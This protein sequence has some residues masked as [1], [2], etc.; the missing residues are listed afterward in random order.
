MI[1]GSVPQ[2]MRYTYS[3]PAG[4]RPG[5]MPRIPPAVMQAQFNPFPS[6]LPQTRAV[7]PFRP[8]LPP[9]MQPGV[10]GVSPTFPAPE[11]APAPVAG[12][13]ASGFGRGV[14]PYRTLRLGMMPGVSIS[15]QSIRS[16]VMNVGATMQRLTSGLP[17]G[18]GGAVVPAGSY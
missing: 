13:G 10:Y 7:M 11:P 2:D 16:G 8:P 4:A 5:F 15:P 9:Q 12:F 17:V 1:L 6:V 18:A 3:R 14:S